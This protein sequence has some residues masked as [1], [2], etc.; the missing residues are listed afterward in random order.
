M[1]VGQQSVK[2]WVQLLLATALKGLDGEPYAVASGSVSIA[3]WTASGGSGDSI[4]C[5]VEIPFEYAV[6]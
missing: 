3:G 5:Y 1:G 4:F 2:N 6:F